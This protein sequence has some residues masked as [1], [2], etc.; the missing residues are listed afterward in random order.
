MHLYLI[1]ENND[2]AAVA[3]QFLPPSERTDTTARPPGVKR[4]RYYA[5]DRH[6]AWR[7]SGTQA[8]VRSYA[9][10]IKA[11][12]SE[13]PPHLLRAAA[14]NIKAAGSELPASRLGLGTGA[15]LL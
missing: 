1:D 5:L 13:L 3:V 12:G 2:G 14:E 11:A 6:P 15:V 4:R 7:F 8:S 10:L 9:H